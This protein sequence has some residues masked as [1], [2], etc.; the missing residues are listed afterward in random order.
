MGFYRELRS[1]NEDFEIIEQRKDVRC[2][3]DFLGK[4]CSR[5]KDQGPGSVATNPGIPSGSGKMWPVCPVVRE[6]VLSSQMQSFVY[7][8]ALKTIFFN[9]KFLIE[10]KRILYLYGFFPAPKSLRQQENQLA[11]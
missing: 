6:Q 11:I 3:R 2:W 9:Y 8:K 7:L 4:C 10:L 5:A 1:E